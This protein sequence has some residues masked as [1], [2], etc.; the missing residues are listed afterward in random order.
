MIPPITKQSRERSTDQRLSFFSSP[1]LGCFS[2]TAG[3]GRPRG[4]CIKE[5]A[6][7]T[8]VQTMFVRYITCR[9]G[10]K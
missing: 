6:R 4:I 9:S 10:E 7:N 5:P 3:G 1:P 8:T 2:P